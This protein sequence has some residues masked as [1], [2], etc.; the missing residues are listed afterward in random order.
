[1]GRAHEEALKA[2]RHQSKK[3]DAQFPSSTGGV[4]EAREAHWGGRG[5]TSIRL[6]WIFLHGIGEIYPRLW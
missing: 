2:D 3:A 6:W 5:G 4:K 1:M